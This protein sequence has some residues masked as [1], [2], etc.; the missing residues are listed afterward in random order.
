MPIDEGQPQLSYKRLLGRVFSS[1]GNPPDGPNRA[2]D[3]MERLLARLEQLSNEVIV[4]GGNYL[5]SPHYITISPGRTIYEIGDAR[6]AEPLLV[7]VLPAGANSTQVGH[8]RLEIVDRQDLVR[9]T[10]KPGSNDAVILSQVYS[11]IPATLPR[12][13]SWYVEGGTPMLAL[14]NEPS[15][16]VTL[17]ILFEPASPFEAEL[18]GTVPFLPAFLNLLVDGAAYDSL[19][20]FPFANLTDRQYAQMQQRLM[21]R[22]ANG[23]RLLREYVANDHMEVAGPVEKWGSDR[24]HH[25]F[26]TMFYPRVL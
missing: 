20:L 13:V 8:V 18:D 15:T 3:V 7:E 11:T 4:S 21:E 5:L 10:Q 16:A 23:E 26:G 14:S 6:F 12:A 2:A 1:L 17:R 22:I 9:F 19:D 25:A 24:S